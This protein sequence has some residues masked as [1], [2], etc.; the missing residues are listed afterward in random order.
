MLIMMVSGNLGGSKG[1]ALGEGMEI[2]CVREIVCWVW[3]LWMGEWIGE[4]GTELD[5]IPQYLYLA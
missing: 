3:K 2:V 4:Y 5:L 1:V